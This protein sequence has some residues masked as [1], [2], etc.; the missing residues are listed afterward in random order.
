MPDIELLS[1]NKGLGGWKRSPTSLSFL[2]E[3]ELLQHG[4][5][6]RR[7]EKNWWPDPPGEIL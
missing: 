2:P 3:I 1:Y 4:A 6:R 5:G 7:D